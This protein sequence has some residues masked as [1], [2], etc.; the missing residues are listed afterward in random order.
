MFFLVTKIKMIKN[1]ALEH[2]YASLSPQKHI[3]KNSDGLHNHSTVIP[4]LCHVQGVSVCPIES[5]TY[6][7]NEKERNQL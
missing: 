7:M 2:C 1:C 6:K 5:L 4:H 3:T